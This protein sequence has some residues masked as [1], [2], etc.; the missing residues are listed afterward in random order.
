VR[1]TPILRID[2][3]SVRYGGV[4]ALHGVDLQIGAGEFCGLIGPNGAGK[5]TLF[6]VVSGH[7]TATEGR[8][9]LDG[10]DVT[11]RSSVWRA[12]H[13]IRRTFQRQQV[14]GALTVAHNVTAAQDWRG[15]GGGF[16]GG[17]LGLPLGKSAQQERSERVDHVLDLCGLTSLRDEYAGNLPIG[18]ARMV[19]VARAVVDPPKLLLLD[20]PTSGLSHEQTTRLADVVSTVRAE[21]GC[22]VLLVEHDVPFVMAQCERVICLSLGEVLAVGTPEEIQQHALVREAYLG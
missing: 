13:G 21:T 5:T 11:R 19:E 16:L 22:A 10:V 17:L 1:A 7:G 8:L 20:E 14:F 12:R 3:V 2:S 18:A 15:G 9:E 6:D 4:F